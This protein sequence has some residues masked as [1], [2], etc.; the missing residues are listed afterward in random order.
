ML[1]ATP[2]PRPAPRQQTP[3]SCVLLHLLYIW[4]RLFFLP[5]VLFLFPPLANIS[6]LSLGANRPR[7]LH[8]FLFSFFIPEPHKLL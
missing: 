6:I 7:S 1:E 2:P 4:G 8:L 3:L 5:V